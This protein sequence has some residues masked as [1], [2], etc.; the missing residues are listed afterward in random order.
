MKQSKL[1]IP[2]LKQDPA[3]A[4]ALSHKMLVRAGFVRQ[5]SAGMYAYLPLAYRVLENIKKVVREELAKT[6]AAEMLM[7]AVIPAQLWKDS[8]R[9]DTY[10]PEL[11]KFKNR[12]DTDFI[13]GPTHEETFT[14]L[15]KNNI[16]SYKKLPLILY[17][18]QPKYRDEDRPRYGLLRSREFIML[19]AYSFSENNDDLDKVYKQM[20]SAFQKIF[21]RIGLNYRTIIGDAGSMGGSDSKEFSAPAAVGEDTIVYSDDSDY[22][23]NLEMATNMFVDQKG[24]ADLKDL[25]LVDTPDVTNINQVSKFFDIEKNQ[26]IKSLLYIVDDKPV[27]ILIRGDQKINP[28]KVKNY[29]NADSVELASPS[30]VQDSLN[31]KPGSVGPIKV[32]DDIPVYADQ[33]V[34]G[35][36]NAV[37]GAN[38]NGKHYKNVN[39]DRDY[40]VKDF[41]DF[42]LVKEGDI[43]PD[44][45]GVLKFTKGI[46]IG[47]IFKLGTRYSKTL[48]ADILDKN[49]R[50]IPVVMGSYGIGISRLL[51][52]VSEQQADQNGLV[53]PKEIAPYDVHIIPTNVEN[54]E[55]LEMTTA[56]EKELESKGLSV[57]VDDR[58]ER[59]GVK[60]ADSDLI[61]I[62]IRVTIGKKADEGI[63]EVKIRKTGETIETKQDDLNNTID[64]L[65]KEI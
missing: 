57:L 19:D 54:D 16:K 18:I 62:P 1:L 29:F 53:W 32:P 2:T 9:Y 52:A 20:E 56:I 5:V 23:A 33:Y 44:G 13:L 3:G 30:E 36:S 24:H 7:P 15:I 22:A 14:D 37:T 25:E 28:T 61:G 11:F 47:H 41:G 50:S 45:S 34:K 43:S 39:Y 8:G 46:E 58:K 40:Q 31:V 21:D 65:S 27:M 51:S 60:F 48:G 17:Q 26:I 55:Q 35:I 63:V 38:E 10:G 6:D 49:G 64:I 4:E 42:H 59:A 12:H